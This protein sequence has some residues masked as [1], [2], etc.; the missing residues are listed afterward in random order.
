VLKP[1]NCD[2]VTGQVFRKKLEGNFAPQ[3]Q[4]FGTINHTHG[5]PAKLLDDSIVRS[6][7]IQHCRCGG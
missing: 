4:V 5:A 1:L 6:N 7:L 3:L 2:S